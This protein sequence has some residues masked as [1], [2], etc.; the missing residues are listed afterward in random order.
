MIKAYLVGNLTAD[1][2]LR[3]TTSGI[4]V[5]TF[6]VAC[7]RR[8]AG[9]NAEKQTEF[10]RVVAWRQLGELCAKYL[11]K[12]RKVAVAGQLQ[13]NEYTDKEGNK[14]TSIEVIADDVEFLTPKGDGGSSYDAAAHTKKDSCDDVGG[15]TEMDDSQLPF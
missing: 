12:G 7:N 8:A 4:S 10:V 11:A 2:E 1:P 9:Q 14:R 5:C 13:T 3:S 6:R 15:F